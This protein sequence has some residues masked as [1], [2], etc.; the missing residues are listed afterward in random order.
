MWIKVLIYMTPEQV[1]M[2]GEVFVDEH[3]NQKLQSL[4]NDGR[5]FLP[6]RVHNEKARPER[7]RLVFVNKRY[8]YKVEETD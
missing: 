4:L 8:I 3:A 5:A 1:R 7:D 2:Y 6:V